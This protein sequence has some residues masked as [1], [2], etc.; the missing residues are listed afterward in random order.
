MTPETEID[1]PPAGRNYG[2][3]NE[4]TINCASDNMS[5]SSASNKAQGHITGGR[6]GRGSNQGRGG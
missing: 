2:D 4:A 5:T 3:R 6:T 1:S